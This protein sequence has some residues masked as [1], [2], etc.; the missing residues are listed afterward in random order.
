MATTFDGIVIGTGQAGPPLAARLAAAGMKVAVVERSRF[1][2]TCVN[3]GCTP[4]KA[5]VASAYAAQLARRAAEYGVDIGGAVQVDMKRVKDRKDAISRKSSQGVEQWLRGLGGGAVFQGHARFE[6]PTRVRVNDT[7][8]EAKRI[9]INV[10]ARAAVPPIPGIDKVPFLTNSGMMEVDFV[11]EHLVIIGGSYIGLEFAQMFRRF[12]AQVTVVE[13]GPRLIPREDVDVSVTIHHILEEEG[14]QVRLDA[15]CIAVRNRP[16]GGIEAGLDCAGPSHTVRSSHLLLAVGRRP[17]TDDLDLEKAG[18][19]VDARGYITVD[20]ALQTTAPGI[21]ALGD[22]NGRGAFTHTAY[23]D[24]EIVADNLLNGGDRRV[25]DRIMTYGLFID[26][27]LGR[28]GMTEAEVR[29]SGRQALIGVRPMSR[30][31]RAVEKGETDGFMKMIVDAQS[32]Q[33]LGAAILGPGGDEAV[34]SLIDLMYAR[35]PY[36]VVRD[37]VHIHPTVSELIPTLLRDLRPFS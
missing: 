26:P 34:H 8:L 22:C 6:G 29:K 10:G 12:G 21:F 15:E 14:V 33:V 17:N 19:G 37:A 23:N 16:G 2:G 4:T 5:M 3:T 9:F 7:V 18:V 11:P 25:T 20:A 27:P 1:G 31:N 35:A 28:V 13:K 24:C 30:V 32:L 36:T